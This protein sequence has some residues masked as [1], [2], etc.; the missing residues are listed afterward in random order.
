[1]EQLNLKKYRILLII[2]KISNKIV[3]SSFNDKIYSI[4]NKLKI[5]L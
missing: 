4:Y 5:I 1:M 2:F 3:L